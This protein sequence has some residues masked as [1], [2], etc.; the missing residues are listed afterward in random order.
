MPTTLSTERM[1]ELFRDCPEQRLEEH[2]AFWGVDG[3]LLV[4]IEHLLIRAK[5]SDDGP[6]RQGL[7]RKA[8]LLRHALDG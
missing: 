2:V 5:E 7:I 1:L 8:N 4:L 6:T 3:V